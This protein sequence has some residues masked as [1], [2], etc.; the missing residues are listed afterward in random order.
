M[1][2]RKAVK[3][4]RGPQ[5]V[6]SPRLPAEDRQRQILDVAAEIFA[7]KSFRDASTAEIAAAAGVSEPALYRHFKSK[8]DLYL[9]AI[10]RSASA[11]MQ[12]MRDVAA[13]GASPMEAVRDVGRWY[14]LRMLDD[15]RPFLLRARS[16]VE[17]ADPEVSEIARR[18]FNEALGFAH[19]LYEAAKA[20]GQIDPDTD[21]RSHAWTFM[22]L[23]TLIDQA[24]LLD[25]KEILNIEE[26]RHLMRRMGPPLLTPLPPRKAENP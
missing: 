15:P 10:D 3:V 18:H 11:L 5:R 7:S 9:T 20:H 19:D 22:S 2:S 24:L 12:D 26:I 21:T 6:R 14:F 4:A 13:A 23:G 16:L 25:M 8:R 1:S 17:A